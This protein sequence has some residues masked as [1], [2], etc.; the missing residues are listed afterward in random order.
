MKYSRVHK[1]SDSFFSKI[2]KKT[3]QKK[4]DASYKRDAFF[5]EMKQ[6]KIKMANLKNS[7]WPPQKNHF[8][9][10]NIFSWT[11]YGLILG[12]VDLIDAKGIGV[13]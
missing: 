1:S 4:N 5:I 6:K 9:A 3:V 2:L 10:P 7:K 13:T 8:Q 12:L 11:F